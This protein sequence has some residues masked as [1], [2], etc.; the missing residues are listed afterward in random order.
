MFQTLLDIKLQPNTTY[1]V[2]FD[3]QVSSGAGPFP[4]YLF[5]DV[6]YGLGSAGTSVFGGYIASADLRSG[7]DLQLCSTLKHSPDFYLH[8]HDETNHLSID[9]RHRN[10]HAAVHR[11]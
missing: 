4:A 8:L 6:S 2:T 1:T 9:L 7:H 10:L 5:T 3:A 11:I